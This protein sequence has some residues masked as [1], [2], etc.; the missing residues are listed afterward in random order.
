MER[1]KGIYEVEKLGVT[2]SAD[3]KPKVGVDSDPESNDY[4][5]YLVETEKESIFVLVSDEHHCCEKTGYVTSDDNLDNFIGADLRS[6]EVVGEDYNI[7]SELLP[8][9]DEYETTFTVFVNFNTDR[10]VLQ[11]AVYNQHNGWYGH[12]VLLIKDK[13]VEEFAV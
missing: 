1:I 5:G 12:D 6:V 3:G 11:M 4:M 2:V 10:G 13:T 7:V 8:D 9:E